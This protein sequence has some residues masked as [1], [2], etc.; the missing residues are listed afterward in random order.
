MYAYWPKSPENTTGATYQVW[1]AGGQS[2]ITVSQ[3]DDGSRWVLLGTFDFKQGQ[4]AVILTDL[5]MDNPP[6]QRVYF[7]AIRWEP[8]EKSYY[9]PGIIKN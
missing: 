4:A 5:T 8:V 3:R 9:L 6:K 1:H 7:D 2:N